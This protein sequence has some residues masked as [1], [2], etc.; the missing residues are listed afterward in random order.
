MKLKSFFF[1][2]SFSFLSLLKGQGNVFELPV[3]FGQYFND[4]QVHSD[5]FEENQKS[6]LNFGHQRLSNNSGSYYTSF[7]AFNLK[8]L[9]NQ[10]KAYHQIGFRLVNDKN[11]FIIDK[12][13]GYINYEYHI[14]INDKYFI[15]GGFLIGLYNLAIEQTNDYEGASEYAIDGGFLF[16]FHSYKTKIQ[17]TVNQIFNSVIQPELQKTILVRNFNLFS[18]HSFSINEQLEII[19]STIIRYSKETRDP[20]SGTVINIGNKFLIANQVDIGMSYDFGNGYYF[21]TGIKNIKVNKS[22]LDFELSYF[23]PKLNNSRT[24]LQLIEIIL[25]YKINSN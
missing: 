13:R 24:N 10:S 9:S 12:N 16:K 14:P 20:L 18:S 21:F 7:I 22:E 25:K 11:G 19:P 15:S 3:F 5:N 17:L 1:I 4:P 23:V 6:I 8:Y 2:I